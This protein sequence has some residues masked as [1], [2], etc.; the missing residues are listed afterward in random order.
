MFNQE[1]INV[2]IRKRKFG[3]IGHILRKEDGETTKAAL[4]WNPRV[5]RKR[6]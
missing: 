1:D 2:Q 6:G 3:W 5:N 4:L